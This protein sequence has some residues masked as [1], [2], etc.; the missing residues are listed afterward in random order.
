MNVKHFT[1]KENALAREKSATLQFPH[2]LSPSPEQPQDDPVVGQ[3]LPLTI[4]ILILIPFCDNDFTEDHF[5]REDC[6][7]SR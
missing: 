2:L 4:L 5:K 3:N 6:L 1:R 7:R